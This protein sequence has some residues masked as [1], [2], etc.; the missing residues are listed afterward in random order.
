MLVNIQAPPLQKI[1]VTYSDSKILGANIPVILKDEFSMLCS[2]E[3]SVETS[4]KEKP[5][6]IYMSNR[7]HK[8][9]VR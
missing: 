8:I 7:V 4:E 5:A 1:L 6:V 2:D 3:D 9:H